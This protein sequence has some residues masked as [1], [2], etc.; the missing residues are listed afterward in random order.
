MKVDSNN[1]RVHENGENEAVQMDLRRFSFLLDDREGREEKRSLGL[2]ANQT[3]AQEHMEHIKKG[4]V[5]TG[6]QT[7]VN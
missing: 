6:I 4:I 7:Q 3:R 1:R 2:M 5:A